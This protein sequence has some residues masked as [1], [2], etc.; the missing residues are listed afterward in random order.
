MLII[1]HR[2]AFSVVALAS[3]LSMAAVMT[4]GSAAAGASAVSPAFTQCP[5]I[6]SASSCDILLVVNPDASV[7]VNGD[8]SQGPYDGSD[9]TLVGIVNNSARP[10][11]AITV[12]GPGS[13]LS[14][15]DGDGICTFSGWTGVS[16]CPYG[17]TGY[18]GPGTSFVTSPSLPDAAEIDFAGGLAP[19]K[20]AYFS[21]EGALT[22]AK[23]AAREGPLAGVSCP[24]PPGTTPVTLPEVDTA[25]VNTGKTFTL[26]YGS[27]PL[28]F[29]SMTPAAGAL[30]TVTSTQPGSLPVN[31]EFGS[32][33]LHVSTSV[34]NATLDFFPADAAITR[35][36]T[37]DFSLVDS[38]GGP[39]A[40][41]S[42]QDFPSTDNCLLLASAHPAGGVI[43][44]WSTPGFSVYVAGVLIH[45]TTPL[46]YYLDLST[47]PGQNLGSAP[48]F[49]AILQAVESY[50]HITLVTHLPMIDKMVLVQDPPA[51]LTVTDPLG[52]T[53]SFS[54]DDGKDSV[55]GSGFPQA[56]YAELGGRSIAWILEPV[57]GKYQVTASGPFNTRFSVDFTVL[58]LLGHGTSPLIQDTT[59]QGTTSLTGRQSKT[60]TVTGS[61]IQ[62]VLAPA[63][64]A[65]DE[66]CQHGA[67]VTT[68]QPVRFTLGDSVIPMGLA[69]ASWSFG[70]G[71]TVTSNTTG[72]ITHRYTTPGTYTLSLTVIDTLGDT[73]TVTLPPVTVHDKDNARTGPGN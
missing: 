7:T 72:A 48:T 68:G 70:D 13:S 54:K 29:A 15:F 62:P 65:D 9:D 39:G 73:V 11:T 12:T 43:V 30:C 66:R 18:E 16:G 40:V 31:I 8:P 33:K 28:T 42:P 1:R 46:T 57:S 34:A 61:A 59:W 51:H 24:P 2:S 67:T 3:A 26:D 5:A 6:G 38:V 22:A 60:F 19:G 4:A 37:C 47:I 69:T 55:S 10:V 41:P 20:S 32:S 56:G 50:I 71:T 21:L 53:I 63:E 14:V 25:Q 17:S 44:R 35:V 64:W 52:R 27:I 23:L 45:K 58:E 36:P 49:A